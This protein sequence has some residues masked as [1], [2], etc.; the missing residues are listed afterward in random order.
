[1]TLRKTTFAGVPF[2]EWYARQVEKERQQREGNSIDAHLMA[3]VREIRHYD[4]P[5]GQMK[6]M[7]EVLREVRE[8]CDRIANLALIDLEDE[9]SEMPFRTISSFR[10]RP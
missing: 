8:D 4:G 7:R 1:M 3:Q 9:I 6:W 10:R 2:D 5:I